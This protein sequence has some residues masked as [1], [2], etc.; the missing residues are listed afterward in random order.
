MSSVSIIIPSYQHAATIARCLDSVLKQTRQA[1]EIIVV[2]DGSTDNTLEILKPYMDKIVLVSQ[3][4]LGGQKARNNGF[5]A[6]AGEFVVFC[7]ADVVMR[8]DMLEKL[9]AVLDEHPEASYAYSGFKF[10]WKSFSSFPFDVGRIKKLN[11]VHTT[12]LIRRVDFP[13]FDSEIKRFQDW[14]LWLT[15]MNEGH[16]GFFVD[17]ELFQV[18]EVSGRRGIS[19]WRPKIFYRIPWKYFGWMPKS[20]KKYEEA[21]EVINKKHNL[22]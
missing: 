4:N 16:I 11:F 3:D 17:E 5:F 6:S 9:L 13:G 8:P 18:I 12:A 10:G 20:V 15:M 7:D 21:K 22:E 14:D 19:K 2:N 1:D